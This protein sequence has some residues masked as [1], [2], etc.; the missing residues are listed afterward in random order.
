MNKFDAV[1][2]RSKIIKAIAHP[3]RLMI[4]EELNKGDKLF[5]Q[6]FNLFDFDKSTI[7]KHLLILKNAGI[8]SSK[9]KGLDMIYKLETKCIIKFLNCIDRVI[10]HSI[11]KTVKCMMCK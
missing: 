11:K 5:S 3:V 9:K 2:L 7:S 1:E 6:L 10:S 4:I 8:V